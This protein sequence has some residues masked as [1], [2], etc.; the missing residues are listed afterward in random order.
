MVIDFRRH[1]ASCTH[2]IFIRTRSTSTES[3][4]RSPKLSG[5]R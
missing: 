5:S 1:L 4:D 2:S 3:E